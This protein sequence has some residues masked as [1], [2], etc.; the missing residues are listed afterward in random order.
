MQKRTNEW[1]AG[2]EHESKHVRVVIHRKEW[3]REDE[4]GVTVS[5]TERALDSID[6]DNPISNRD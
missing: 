3:F 2:D 6:R 5:R 1:L 4:P